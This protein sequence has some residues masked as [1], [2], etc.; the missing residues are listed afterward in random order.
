MLLYMLNNNND[1]N[2]KINTTWNKTLVLNL[3]VLPKNTK[4]LDE[5]VV[6]YT[7]AHYFGIAEYYIHIHVLRVCIKLYLTRYVFRIMNY[8]IQ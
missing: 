1:S 6:Q 7:V 3:N 5:Q 8:L 2:I 4:H